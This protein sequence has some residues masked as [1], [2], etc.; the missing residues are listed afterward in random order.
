MIHDLILLP[1]AC[2]DILDAAT[3][4]EGQSDGLGT[5]FFRCIDACVNLIRRQPLIYGILHR[6]FR[7]ALVRRFPYAVFF[8]V[9]RNAVVIYSVFHCA[10]NP[11][12]WRNRIQ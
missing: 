5:E 3:W 6:N 1:E 9:D 11:S 4:Y 2:Q 7:R 8:E 12:A 10:R